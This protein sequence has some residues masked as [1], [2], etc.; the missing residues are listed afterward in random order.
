M[1]HVQ[2]QEPLWFS[3]N[4]IKDH[5]DKLG[6]GGAGKTRAFDSLVGSLVIMDIGYHTAHAFQDMNKD[7]HIEGTARH[8]LLEDQLRKALC[9]EKGV[10]FLPRQVIRKASRSLLHGINQTGEITLPDGTTIHQ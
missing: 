5:F 3:A 4:A 10:R 1:Q 2:E 9:R 6:A 8:V 7:W